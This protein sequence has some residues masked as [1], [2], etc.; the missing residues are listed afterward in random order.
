M[1]LIIV[2]S[3]YISVHLSTSQYISGHRSTFQYISVHLSISQYIAVH[4]STSQYISVHRSTS[5]YISASNVCSCFMW[6]I[7]IYKITFFGGGTT[8]M[9]L[10]V[11]SINHSL[12]T[13]TVCTY[14]FSRSSSKFST[15]RVNKVGFTSQISDVFAYFWQNFWK[16]LCYGVEAT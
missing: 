9:L 14:S 3:Q 7:F 10:G 16:Y 15:C 2:A 1:L 11:I 6:M 4:H 12:M 5:Q 13:E 8:E